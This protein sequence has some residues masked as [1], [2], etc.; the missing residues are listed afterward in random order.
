METVPLHDVDESYPA[1][2]PPASVPEYISRKKA[3]AYASP[4]NPGEILVTADTVVIDNDTV[5]GKPY[6]AIDAAR[7][8][9]SLSGHTHMVVTGVTLVTSSASISFSDTTYVEFAELSDKEISY[10]IDNYR[11]FDKAGAYGIQEWIGYI[12]IKGIKGDYYNVMGLPLR[13]LYEHLRR[14]S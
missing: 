4:L 13:K 3:Q 9:T 7:M 8:L 6:D 1:T 11:P 2:L 12:G 14:I 5:L 10:Y